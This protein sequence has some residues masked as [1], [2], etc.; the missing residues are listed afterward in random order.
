LNAELD[1]GAGRDDQRQQILAAAGDALLER[2]YLA[3]T[4]VDISERAGVCA[5]AFHAHFADK[6]DCLLA[7]HR[8]ASAELDAAIAAACSAAPV[9]PHDVIAAVRAAMELFAASPSRASLIALGSAGVEGELAGA[10]LAA[11]RRL[12]DRLRVA[13]A[14]AG[15]SEEQAPAWLDE[16]MIA[17]AHWLVASRLREGEADRLPAFAG[18]ISHLLLIAYLGL[19]ETPKAVSTGSKTN[20]LP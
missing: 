1:P 4:E 10:I 5:D 12:A 7:A 16:M 14:L 11:N 19:E 13:A 6:H 2:G 15:A 20:G 17:G 9:W 18:E 8:V 3:L